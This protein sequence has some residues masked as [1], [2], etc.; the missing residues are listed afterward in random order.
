MPKIIII[1]VSDKEKESRIGLPFPHYPDFI[2]PPQ[3]GSRSYRYSDLST[4]LWTEIPIYSSFIRLSSILP[5]DIKVDYQQIIEKVTNL[6]ITHYIRKLYIRRSYNLGWTQRVSVIWGSP[7]IFDFPTNLKPGT[8]GTMGNTLYDSDYA[9]ADVDLT[10]DYPNVLQFQIT[11]FTAKN[12]AD[13][14]YKS[15][16][17]TG[18]NNIFRYVYII[19]EVSPLIWQTFQNQI[20]TAHKTLEFTF[21]T[22]L[23]V[24]PKFQ[25]KAYKDTIL[26]TVYFHFGLSG[27]LIFA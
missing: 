12:C 14:N 18:N 16:P 17:L 21:G 7:H 10:V 13:T 23:I 1:P 25:I 2:T 24:S 5:I 20:S 27:R 8:F 6:D 22:P 11:N 19:D 26:G 15:E 3:F 4:T 9:V